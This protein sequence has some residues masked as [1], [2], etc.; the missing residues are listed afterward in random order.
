MKLFIVEGEKQIKS[1]RDP[2]EKK[3]H[4]LISESAKAKQRSLYSN[5]KWQ[6]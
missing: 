4:I 3:F 5:S 2:T 1:K 6:E